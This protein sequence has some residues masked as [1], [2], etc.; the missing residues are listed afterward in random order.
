MESPIHAKSIPYMDVQGPCTEVAVG[1]DEKNWGRRLRT[2]DFIE[3]VLAR[4]EI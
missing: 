2:P 4:D 1:G 3:A